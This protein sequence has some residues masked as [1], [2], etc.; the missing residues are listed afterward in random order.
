MNYEFYNPVD[1]KGSC[2]AR[3]LSKVF[4]KD[5]FKVKEELMS[6]SNRLNKPDYRDIDVFE[7]YLYDNK[8]KKLDIKDILVK[9]LKLDNGKYVVFCYKGDWYHMVSIIN[10]TVYDKTKDSLDLIIISVYKIGD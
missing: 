8:A 4:D 3:S 9:D 6:L 10:N 5:Y 2:I 1:E 7:K